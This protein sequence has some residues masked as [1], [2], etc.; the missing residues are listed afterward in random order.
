MVI[1]KYNYN[2][3]LFDL[4]G[5]V[6]FTDKYHYLA[7][8]RLADEAGW[9][10][11]ET[12]NHKLRGVSRLDSL[13]IVLDHN[14]IVLQAE[15]K[16]ELADRKNGYYLEFLKDINESDLYPGVISF[17]KALKNKGT[18][19]GLC[20]SSKNA[21]FVLEKLNIKELFDVIIT[22]NDI[23][24][25][26]PD[27]EIFQKAAKE[28]NV[29]ALN[30]IVFEDAPT[31]LQAAAAA[32]M[33]C[34]GVGQADNLA[35]AEETIISYEEI[36]IDT[37]LEACSK[38]RIAI[39]PWKIIETEINPKKAAYW[40][41]LFALSNGYMGIRST[42][43]EEASNTKSHSIQ[44]MYI[45]SIYDYP[46]Y[47]QYVCDFKGLP[48]RIHTMLNLC[49]WTTIN[50]EVEDEK[51]SLFSGKILDYRRELDLKCG[52]LNRFVIWESPKGR[53]VS[54]KISRVVSMERRHSAVIR[55]E[56]K[57]LNFSGTIYLESIVKGKA[58]NSG[59]SFDP[60]ERL[61]A[62]LE[63]NLQFFM[64]K[65]RTENFK[66]AVTI[67]HKL[68]VENV[69]PTVDVQET[70]IVSRFALP[71]NIG[72]YI[73][74]DKHAVFFTNIEESGDLILKAKSEIGKNI[75]DGFQILVNEQAV[76]WSK[77]WD[78]A[79]IE[80]G[81]NEGDQQIIRFNLF[82]LRQNHPEAEHLS[83][84]ATGMTGNLYGGLVFWDTEMYMVPHYNYT[85]P[86]LVR[87]LL[88]YRYNI[89]D[90]ARERAKQLDGVG[91]LY[92]W[93]SISGEETNALPE[94]STA[95]YHINPDIAYAIW[96]YYRN[97]NDVEFIN[98]Y[99]AEI[100]FETA[101][102]LADRGKFIAHKGG[103]FCINCVC[104]PD[105][106]GCLVN[107]NC[108]TNMMVQ[109]H[110]YFAIEIYNRMKKECPEILDELSTNLNMGSADIDLWQRAADNMYIPF[111]KELGIHEQ[112]DS[113]L[114]KDPFDMSTIPRNFDIRYSHYPLNLWRMQITK[115]A[116]VV[117]LMLVLG[118]KFSKAVKKANYEFYEP[119]TCHGSSL[120]PSLHSII[121]SEIGLAQDAYDFFRQ[122]LYMDV[123]D[124]RRNTYGGVHFACVGGTWMAIINGF[125]GMRDY[126]N[127]LIFEPKLPKEWE[128][129]SFKLLYRGSLLKVRIDR[130][131]ASFKLLEGKPLSF[132]V[133]DRDI[134]LPELGIDVAVEMN[135]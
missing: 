122:S 24:K 22:G 39:D 14:S 53:Q 46:K 15:K 59:Y 4:D 36:E 3:V 112:D 64:Y 91:A 68:N 11:D 51:F 40:E 101:R 87:Q 133:Y 8:K 116:D 2:T 27:P 96:R 73:C 82:Q 32:G 135:K 65:T 60:V 62:G 67:S 105:E 34:I 35:E 80:I 118:D 94:C 23:T 134:E 47:Y 54:I 114:Y 41:S 48:E 31:G 113:Y 63:G 77:Y 107:N 57:P 50:L 103:R 85:E 19:I 130:H 16:S 52:I 30:C 120:S 28:L 18:K 97:T 12:V 93:M 119:R 124:F 81:G 70:D 78:K 9:S 71:V 43:E 98:N 109:F 83:I 86:E 66:I 131:N 75:N 99:G 123:S 72:E 49:D 79:D 95:Q 76:F 88:M 10:F 110:F 55:Y 106:Y 6:V 92:S 117:L 125:A 42:F 111:N 108:Y 90:R 69:L 61:E 121:A 127:E 126:D 56:V 74:L 84:S 21:G 44:G 26:K 100:L 128:S 29:H 25:S 129:Y 17:I 89:L 5:V 58:Q 102:Y 104:G 13:Q 7:W 38:K 33:K 37:L 132:K 45:N 1:M 20:S 115:Q